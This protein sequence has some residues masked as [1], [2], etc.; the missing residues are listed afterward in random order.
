M[1]SFDEAVEHVRTAARPGQF[2]TVP[3]DTASGRVLA[4]PIIARIDSPRCDVSA[5]DGYAMRDSDLADLPARLEIAG[6]SFAGAAWPDVLA[7]GKCVRIFTG[8]PVPSGADRVVMQEHVL[9]DGRFAVIGQSPGPARHIRYRGTDFEQGDQL[10]QRGRILDKRAIVA[11]AGADLDQVQ[12]Y[13]QPRVMILSTGDELADPGTA[14]QR[15]DAIPESVSLG[16]A[17]LVDEWGGKVIGREHLGDELDHLRAAAVEAV[18]NADL[19]VVTGGAS[20]GERDFAKAM[21][22]PMG[23][24]LIFSKVA[25]KPGKPV[26]LGRVGETLLMGLPGNPTSALVIARLLLAPLLASLSGRNVDVA[27]CWREARLAS[28]LNA[29]GARETFHRAKWA[30]T[31]VEL[32]DFQDSS[33]QRALAEADLLLRQPA[34]SPGLASGDPVQV[35]DF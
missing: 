27:L 23:L 26:W 5:M 17:A 11:A 15:L 13:S 8:A 35:L 6:E 30:K 9:R 4:A 34:N 32:L 2:E 7:L 29:C 14:S 21:F 3:I 24:E 19:V 33:A 1:I 10:L 28:R 22:E 25:I 20:V 16:V 31:E 12:V 18:A